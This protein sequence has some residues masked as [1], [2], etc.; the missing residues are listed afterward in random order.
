[1]YFFLA[2]ANEKI[3]YIN[4]PCLKNKNLNFNL[5]YLT[6]ESH[7]KNKVGN[8]MNCNTYYAFRLLLFFAFVYSI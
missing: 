8:K 4:S 1:M 6:R 7:I 3:L 2:N 5:Q